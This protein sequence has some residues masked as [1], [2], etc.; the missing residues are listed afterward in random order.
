[1]SRQLRVIVVVLVDRVPEQL[2][3][4]YVSR[5]SIQHCEHLLIKPLER[6][7]IEVLVLHEDGEDF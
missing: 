7:P 6:L 5:L 2:P 4:E 3:M 1:M